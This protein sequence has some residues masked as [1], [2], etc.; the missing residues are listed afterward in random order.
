MARLLED[1]LLYAKPLELDLRPLDLEHLVREVLDS[2]QDLVRRPGQRLRFVGPGSSA[3]ILGD[4][5]RLM[6]ILLNL[7][8]NACE[9]SPE[10]G[11]IGWRISEDPG[12]GTVILEV[13][14]GG[15]P[16]PPELLTRITD[17]F[18]T[19]RSSG[20][21]LGLSIVKRLVIAHGG[22]LHIHSQPGEGTLVRLTF[23]PALR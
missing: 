8:R 4:R 5:D 9:A 17:P 18:V 19:G 14:N 10:S 6:Q 23:P 21:G 7:A 11:V 16:I 1:M 15:D 2:E 22:E 20:T 13:H 12:A 3:R